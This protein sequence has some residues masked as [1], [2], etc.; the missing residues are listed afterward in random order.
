MDVDMNPTL[1]HARI[2]VSGGI[3]FPGSLLTT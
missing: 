2:E 1:S 3:N